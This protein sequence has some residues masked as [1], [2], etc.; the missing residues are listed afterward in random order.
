MPT[1]EILWKRVETT[2]MNQFY[3]IG[4]VDSSQATVTTNCPHELIGQSLVGLA[5]AN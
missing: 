3:E 5:R 2:G 1:E 4:G